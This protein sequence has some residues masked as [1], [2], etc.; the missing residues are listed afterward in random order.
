[1][2][3]SAIAGTGSTDDLLFPKGPPSQFEVTDAAI[4]KNSVAILTH[5]LA[6]TN[7]YRRRLAV[8][9]HDL[10]VAQISGLARCSCG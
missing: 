6:R 5:Q 9:A 3:P 8:I 1:M 4:L 2:I 7:H 10:R